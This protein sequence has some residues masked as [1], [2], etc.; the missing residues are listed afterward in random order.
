MIP[1]AILHKFDRLA[2]LVN[3]I[4][5]AHLPCNNNILYS[6]QVVCTEYAASESTSQQYNI[7]ASL[8]VHNET[9]KKWLSYRFLSDFTAEWPW[10]WWRLGIKTI[11]LEE[12]LDYI[13]SQ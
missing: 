12:V 6:A 1:T 10:W 8:F 3:M 11:H 4:I 7:S 2:I 9:S 5:E 13:L